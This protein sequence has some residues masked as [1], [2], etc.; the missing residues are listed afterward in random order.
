MK[1]N[2][3]RI[4]K[5]L[6][7][8]FISLLLLSI[9]FVGGIYFSQTHFLFG[10]RIA[11]VPCSF[12]SIEK[13][14]EKINLEKGEE[15]VTFSFINDKTYDV[16]SKELGIRVDE[17]RIAQI[18]EQQHVNYKEAREYSLN[19]FILANPEMLRKFLRQIPELQEENMVEPQNAYM[20]WDEIAFSIQEEVLGNVIDFEE[21]VNL[22]LKKTQNGERHIDFSL[23][24]DVTP[25]ILEEDLVN[26]RDELNSILK[27]S[28]NF[29]LS[30]GIFVILDSTTIKSWIK[31]D[32]NGKFTIDVESGVPE[33]VEY[34]ATRVNEA[35]SYMQFA[36]TD[37]EGF[38]TLNVPME[39]RAQLDKESEIAEIMSMLGA[40]EPI[41]T[42]PIYDR[43]LISEN[44]TNYLELDKSRQHVWFYKELSLLVDTLC[45]TGNVRDGYDTPSGMFHLLNKN[46]DV[47]L[48]GFNKDGSKYSALVKYWMRFYEGYG[49]HDATWRNKFGG[50]IYKTS[51]SHGCVNVPKDAAAKIYEN[52]D[53]TVLII[54]YQSES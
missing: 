38:I 8:I 47:T 14:I 52:I 13:A 17:T 2:K 30:N 51:G 7:E 45:V 33:F 43:A 20:V 28:I 1:K 10:T 32:E 15:I 49:I 12:L 54:I 23:I 44:L 50:T 36:P 41:N 3:L 16:A 40:S 48:E 9:T 6:W 19:G 4:R 39:L 18:F 53:E 42:K 21:A 37:Y 22:A 11:N 34:L 29:E 25:E 46:M 31:Q 27:S 35:N 5:A 24:T 26:E